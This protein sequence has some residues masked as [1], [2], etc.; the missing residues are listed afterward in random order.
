MII[1]IPLSAEGCRE[2]AEKLRKYA[3][4]LQPKSEELIRKL[5][6]KGVK[7]ANLHL[8]HDDTGETKNSIQ[9]VQ[10]GLTGTL[11]AGG[12]A[13]WIEF[14][15]GVLANAGKSPHPKRDEAGMVAWGEYEEGQGK[16]EWIFYSHYFGWTKTKGIPMNHF[17]YSAAQDMRNDLI[18]TAREVFKDD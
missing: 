3:E 9:Y 5:G 16:G 13:V 17:M 4:S 15:T 12:A 18:D 2:A 7:Y 11:S 8:I 1:D 10:E 14:G 6:E